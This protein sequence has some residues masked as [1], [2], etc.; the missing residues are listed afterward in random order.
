M[1]TPIQHSPD[2]FSGS[3]EMGADAT[4]HSSLASF[5]LPNISDG[6]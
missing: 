6:C 4:A 2:A 5:A 3:P 1:L